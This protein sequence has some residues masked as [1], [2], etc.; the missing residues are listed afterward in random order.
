MTNNAQGTI[1][2]R[3]LRNGSTSAVTLNVD[4]QLLQ[5]VAI[6]DATGN[7]TVA[8]DWTVAANQP[9]IT[10]MLVG[11]ATG[12]TLSD[13]RWYY[14]GDTYIGNVA[15]GSINSNFR[16]NANGS[17]TIIGNLASKDN[18]FT[19]TVTMKAEVTDTT[20][21]TSGNIEKSIDIP[22]QRAS[23]SGYTVLIDSTSTVL[24]TTSSGSVVNSATLTAKVLQGVTDVTDSVTVKFFN[25]LSDSTGT[26]G[27]TLTVSRSD[28]NGSQ[29]YIARAFVGSTEVDAE[30]I[31]I[32]D[33]SDEYQVVTDV[34]DGVNSQNNVTTYNVPES[35]ALI[36]V[37]G[38]AQRN[39]AD[40]TASSWV[41]SKVHADTQKLIAE[42]DGQSA[43]TT[44]TTVAN[45]YNTTSTNTITVLDKDYINTS[46]GSKKRA[47]VFVIAQAEI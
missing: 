3:K 31:T 13:I 22:I 7:A 12:M 40:I 8:P 37:T 18:L 10:P 41:T 28:V 33:S 16:I 29:L 2:L 42:V 11:G 5:L 4:K 30:G 15:S 27:K 43:F 25:G 26:T 1:T 6:N 23:T 44:D 34:T 14:N 35:T 20:G 9:T 19:D 38:R 24:G 32:L 47:E 46:S 21:I 36:T 39:G 17:L 45:S